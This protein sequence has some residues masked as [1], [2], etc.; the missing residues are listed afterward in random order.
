MLAALVI[1]MVP[2]RRVVFRATRLRARRDTGREL[3][4]DMQLRVI[5]PGSGVSPGVAAGGSLDMAHARALRA[6]HAGQAPAR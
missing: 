1:G 5:N 6:R 2:R 4:Q 3:R